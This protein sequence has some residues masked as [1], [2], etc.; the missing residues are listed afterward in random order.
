MKTDTYTRIVLTVIA[1]CLLVLTART[2]GVEPVAHASQEM[3][4]KG[5]LTANG[6][7]GVQPISGGYSVNVRCQ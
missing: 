7:G 4:C 3:T 2:L 1:A 5:E 6:F